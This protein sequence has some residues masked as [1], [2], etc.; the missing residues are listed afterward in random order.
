[1]Q[2]PRIPEWEADLWWE[3]YRHLTYEQFKQAINTNSERK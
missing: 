3:K 1:M 2:I